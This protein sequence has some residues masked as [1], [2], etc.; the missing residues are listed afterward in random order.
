MM[1]SVVSFKEGVENAREDISRIRIGG[2][3]MCYRN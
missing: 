1:C 2:Y 3:K